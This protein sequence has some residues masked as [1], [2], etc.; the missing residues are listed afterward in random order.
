MFH[1]DLQQDKGI[2]MKGTKLEGRE[3]LFEVEYGQSRCNIFKKYV[4]VS[5][6][7]DIEEGFA[8]Q[9]IFSIKLITHSVTRLP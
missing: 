2:G 9:Y 4:I 6:L 8:G 5:S 3:H 1:F 7:K